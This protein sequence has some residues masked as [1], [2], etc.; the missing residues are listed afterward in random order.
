MVGLIDKMYPRD[1]RKV[2]L[3]KGQSCPL[4]SDLIWQEVLSNLGLV[5]MMAHR[6]RG[7]GLPFGDLVQA[8]ILGLFKAVKYFD[9][10]KGGFPNYACIKIKA[11]M[12]KALVDNHQTIRIPFNKMR[13]VF[14]LKKAERQLE[15]EL[16]S[17]PNEEELAAQLSLTIERVRKIKGI[18]CL[19]RT[20]SLETAKLDD[21][22][23]LNEVLVDKMS[24]DPGALIE[25]RRLLDSIRERTQRLPER[26]QQILNLRYGLSGE[27]D[28]TQEE[29]AEK[30][31]LTGEAIRQTTEKTIEY[32]RK[33][34]S[35]E[36]E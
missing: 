18:E 1:L 13:A 28:H 23:A 24:P 3:P 31:G 21:R 8:G 10:D 25:R 12:I 9:P 2:T 7:R 29:V 30:F 26:K 22:R 4:A 16:G 33:V 17:K 34:F 11:E 19:C 6:F 14:Q 35:R 20:V 32:L 5:G 27:A 15:K 36:R